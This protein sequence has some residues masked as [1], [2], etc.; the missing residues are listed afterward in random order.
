MLAWTYI[1]S[2]ANLCQTLGLHRLSN[3]EQNNST[4]DSRASL[5]WLVFLLEKS[6]ALC[7]GRPSTLREAEIATPLPRHGSMKR[8]VQTSIIQGRI[9]DDLYSPPRLARS[10][11]ERA[12]IAQ[13]LATELREL[14]S[15]NEIAIQV[16][17]PPVP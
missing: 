13:A 17:H 10:D 4:Q 16:R 12:S 11:I 14:I 1:S 8:C 5:F 3:P 15:E 6:L 9:Y 7:L 2:A